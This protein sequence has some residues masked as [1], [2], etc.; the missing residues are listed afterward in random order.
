MN[1]DFLY[2]EAP[3]A[4]FFLL[5]WPEHIIHCDSAVTSLDFS[6]SGPSQLAVGMYDGSIA[7][8]DLQSSNKLCVINS[9]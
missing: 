2:I 4:M 1:E 9:R 8:Y 3:V 6:A 7:I 5:Q